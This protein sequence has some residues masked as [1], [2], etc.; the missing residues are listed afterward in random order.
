MVAELY[1]ALRKA[2][3]EEDTARAAA[4]PVLGIEQREQLATKSDIAL[5]KPDLHALESTLTCRMVSVMVAMTALFSA[6]VKL[7]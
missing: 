6:I 5:L 7:T 4:R 2:G 3:V 1:D